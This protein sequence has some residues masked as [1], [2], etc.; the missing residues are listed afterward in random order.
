MD[1]VDEPVA[2][3]GVGKGAGGDV[4]DFSPS[5]SWRCGLA[6]EGGQ[7]AVLALAQVAAQRLLMLPRNGVGA[8]G[9]GGG[10]EAAEEDDRPDFRPR[11]IPG[12]HR[13]TMKS[14]AGGHRARGST[15]TTMYA[16]RR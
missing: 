12:W 13:G 11:G 14:G 5:R 2:G 8:V 1:E 7:L 6:L 15:T 9:A 4:A 16:K 10:A 3:V